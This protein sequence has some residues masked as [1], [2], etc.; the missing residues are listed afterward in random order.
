MKCKNRS[1]KGIKSYV[2]LFLCYYDSV[3]CPFLEKGYESWRIL[4]NCVRV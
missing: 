3:N 2:I 4:V 1:E